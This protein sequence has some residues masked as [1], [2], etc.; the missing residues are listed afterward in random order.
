MEN[1][2]FEKSL[3]KLESIVHELESGNIELESA[4]EK[5]T[6]AMKLVKSC[7][8]KLNEATKKVNKILNE[9]GELVDFNLSEDNTE[10]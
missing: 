3:E 2:S 10:E 7:S 9:N 8:D 1:L 6:E 5:Y 4:I